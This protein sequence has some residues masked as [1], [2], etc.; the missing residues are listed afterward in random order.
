[1]L[2]RIDQGPID[3]RNFPSPNDDW[4]IPPLADDWE[5]VSLT[6]YDLSTNASVTVTVEDLLINGFRC[7]ALGAN[8]TMRNVIGIRGGRG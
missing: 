2:Q 8:V 7:Q 6:M 3:S 4:H 1:V 5:V